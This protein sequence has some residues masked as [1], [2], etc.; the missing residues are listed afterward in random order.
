M[1]KY[2]GSK[3]LFVP[4]LVDIASQIRP[5]GT[6]IDLFSG[7][8]RVGKGLK[9]AGFRVLSNDI[10]T[11]ATTLARCYV[12]SDQ[13]DHGDALEAQIAHL[14]RLPGKAGY[15]T[16]TF[17]E[18]GRFFQ[19]KNGQRVDAIRDWIEAADLTPETRAILLVSLMEAADRVDSTTGVQMAYLK[20][21]APRA[22]KD[23]VLRVPDLL[24]RAPS[25]KGKAHCMDATTAA[26]TLSGH[27]AY[28]DPPYNQHKYV[29]NYHV[30]ETLVRWD[31]PE[32]YGVARKR[33]DCKA[34][35]SA[36]NSKPRIRE[37]MEDVVSHLDVE[38]LVVS[39]NNEGYLSRSDLVELLSKRGEVVVIERPHKRYVGAQ[40]G[41]FNPA[42]DRVGN[43]SHLKNKEFVFVVC[44]DPTAVQ[45]RFQ[46]ANADA[47]V[48]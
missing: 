2:I 40:I 9:Q 18:E 43:V 22:H 17:C 6:V 29:G 31:A 15:F 13:Q 41:V 39:F 35:K 4:L 20:Q 46:T 19:P 33:L 21:W 34:R 23:L 25:G 30:W 1:I 28:L 11:Y 16:R 44:K 36:F 7:T 47:I 27:I 26:R 12:E 3:R 48:D 37:A 38:S 42:G 24:P 14:N 5:S 10:N 32:A 45:R 8:S